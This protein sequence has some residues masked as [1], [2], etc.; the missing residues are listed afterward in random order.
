VFATRARRATAAANH[1]QFLDRAASGQIGGQTRNVWRTKIMPA[2][3]RLLGEQRSQGRIKQDAPAG[4]VPRVGRI[5]PPPTGCACDHDGHAFALRAK[6][7]HHLHLLAV[8]G[9]WLARRKSHLRAM[10]ALMPPPGAAVA[11]QKEWSSSSTLQTSGK[12]GIAR[13]LARHGSDMFRPSNLLIGRRRE[14]LMVRMETYP[15]SA[16]IALMG[17]CA[18]HTTQADASSRRAQEAVQMLG[19]GRLRS[20]FDR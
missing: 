2:Q 9:R 7:I 8:V 10:P 14:D 11:C 20:R 4:Q 16:A 13:S 12:R 5:P 6:E 15:T 3:Q 18:V 17:G 1:W 19:K